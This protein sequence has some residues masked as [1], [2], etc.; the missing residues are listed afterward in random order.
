MWEK[1]EA[2]AEGVVRTERMKTRTAAQ[3]SAEGTCS[4]CGREANQTAARRMAR[5]RGLYE[6]D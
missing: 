1:H 2:A 6:M 5:K 3:G 4:T